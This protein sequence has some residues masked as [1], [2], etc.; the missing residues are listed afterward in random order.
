MEAATEHV[1]RF[2]RTI[3]QRIGALQEGYLARG[4]PLG[5]SRVLS[6][7]G[8]AG[9]DVRALRARL[10]LDSGYLSRL[11]RRLEHEG[12]V[13]REPDPRDRR[14][15]AV[16]LTEA[17]RAERA[18]LD[19][20]SDELARSLLD[21]LT[22]A[23]RS[24][25]VD[26]M[27]L[28]E[29]LLVAGAVETYIEDPTSPAA[30]LCI[31]SYF[32]ELR[33]RFEEGFD[34]ARSVLPDV[35]ELVEPAGLLLVARLHG[36]PVGCGGLQLHDGGVADVKRMWIA[37]SVRGLGLGRRLLAELE[38]HARRRG[39]AVVRLETNRALTEAIALYRSAGYVD[40][41]RFNDEPYGDHWFAKELGPPVS[42]P[43]S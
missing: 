14:V 26:A 33:T 1:R 20:K 35:G 12:L 27:R 43:P 41:P 19:T 18:V 4:R 42:T 25:L 28:V 21:P 31:G 9:V 2:N 29:R 38:D 3:T 32:E 17:G 30:R 22:E 34:P 11:L 24:Q 37:P 6:E 39:V 10:E 13:A 8:D 16:R 5:A 36:E 15:R 7:I 40:V 23:Q